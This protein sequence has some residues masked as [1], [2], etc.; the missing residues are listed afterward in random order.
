MFNLL[1][2]SGAGGEELGQ[3]GRA[4]AGVLQGALDAVGCHVL[5]SSAGP[6]ESLTWGFDIDATDVSAHVVFSALFVQFS[7]GEIR[8]TPCARK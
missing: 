8:E 1:P 3:G 5:S 4:V 7:Y 2:R 6:G